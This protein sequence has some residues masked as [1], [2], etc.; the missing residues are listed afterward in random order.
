[1]T[2][3]HEFDRAFRLH[4]QGKLREAFMRYDAVLAADPDNAA[5]LHYSGVVLFQAGKLPEAA[6]RIRASLAIEPRSAD[7]WSNLAMV[8]ESAGRREA[9]ANALREAA[10]LA[11]TS[12]EILA[13]LSAAELALGRT[14][15][16]ESSARRAIAAHPTHAPAWH[17][18]ALSLEPQ[19]RL[20]EAMDAASRATA[21]SPAEPLRRLQGAAQATAGMRRRRA[22]PLDA[23]LARK[24]DSAPLQF[25]LAGL[26]EREGDVSGAMQAYANA[27]RLDRSTALRCR[28]SYSCG[29]A[30]ATGATSRRCARSSMTA[31]PR[32]RRCCRPLCCCRSHRRGTSSCAAPARGRCSR[33]L[34]EIVSAGIE[35]RPPAHQLPV[36]RPACTTA[37]LAAGLFEAHD[38]SRFDIVAYSTGPDDR[39]PMRERLVRGFDRFVDAAGWPALRLAQAIRDDGIDI[40]VDLKG[41]RGRR[42]RGLAL[43]PHRSRR[44]TSAIPERSAEP[45]SIT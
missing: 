22:R 6:E 4:Q 3:S 34:S 12:A 44:I 43:R 5:A 35:R 16:A 25:Q 11:P 23:A 41:H 38:R 42:T 33:R 45:S 37:Y 14:A 27:V 24:P 19:G 31:S 10:K 17:N 13:N 29:S 26:L 7:A 8:L 9:A 15:E 21:Q 39:S 30:S 1:M 2:I 40:L 20:L 32:A 28:S 36:R 18:L